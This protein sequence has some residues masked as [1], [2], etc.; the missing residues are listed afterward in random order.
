M[1]IAGTA[2]IVRLRSRRPPGL[3]FGPVSGLQAIDP[4][5]DGPDDWL[6]I[7]GHARGG[8]SG[9]AMFNQRAAWSACFGARIPG[10][11]WPTPAMV[12]DAAEWFR[13]S[14]PDVFGVEANQFQDFFMGEFEAE[15]RRQGILAARPVPIENHTSKPVRIRRLGPYLSSR[16]WRF[17]SASPGTRML[18]EQLQMFPVADHDDGPDASRW[19]C[20]WPSK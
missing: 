3:Q 18:V 7:S 2:G 14:R 19:R 8:D 9:G 20:D 10:K 15:F 6:D 16:R 17:K 11:R 12:A 4:A 1:Q 5:P 13:R